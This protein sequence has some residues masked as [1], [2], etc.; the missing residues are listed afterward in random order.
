MDMLGR[1]VTN[2]QPQLLGQLIEGYR[3]VFVLMLLGFL[4]HFAPAKWET[5]F[6]HRVIRLPLLGKVALMV[7]LI[8]LVIQVKSSDIQPFIYFRF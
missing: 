7:V 2:F 5:A 1:I 6:A 3:Y 4:L 8:Y